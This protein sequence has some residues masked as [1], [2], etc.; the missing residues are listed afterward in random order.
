MQRLLVVEFTKMNGAGNDFVV[1]D[2]RFYA[3]SEAELAAL[4]RDL[5]RRTERV[6]ADGLL[7]L[8]HGT[9]G[10]DFRMHYHNADGSRGTMCGNGA[11]CLARFAR[12]AG[13][14][15]DPFVFDTDAGRL[16]ADVPDDP[17]ADVRLHL[18]PPRDLRPL[19]LGG[20]D[21]TFV[22]TGTEHIVR[23]VRQ[24]AAVDLVTIGP[25]LRH[26]PC[27]APRGANVNLVEVAGPDRLRVRT[28]EK[29]VEAETRACGTGAMAS[30]LVAFYTGRVRHAPVA[31]EMP[32]GTLMVGF[33]WTPGAPA[34]DVSDL[35]LAGP[36]EATFRG[37]VEVDVRALQPD[38]A[39]AA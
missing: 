9:D 14:D 33:T 12:A 8:D 24:A 3:F 7:A 31:V 18:P 35:T 20:L 2:N 37:T 25:A 6:G 4:A 13:L 23:F 21:A 1:L 36:A 19:S 16:R 22:W 30:A 28:Y 26:D 11:R 15:A 17:A 32:G 5:C 27:L 38:A 10:A 34:E 29:G 39:P